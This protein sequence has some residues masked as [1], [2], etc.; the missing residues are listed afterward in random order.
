MQAPSPSVPAARPSAA[1][2]A[3][4]SRMNRSASRSEPQYLPAPGIFSNPAASAPAG[5][6]HVVAPVT[7]F[8]SSL[9]TPPGL[10][11]TMYHSPGVN[12]FADCRKEGIWKISEELER[13][14]CSA[15]HV[16]S[17]GGVVARN[18]TLSG[19][20]DSA[21]EEAEHAVR[22]LKSGTG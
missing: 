17:W 12:C 19:C 18:E 1:V 13:F 16:Q 4:L 14:R 15:Y 2:S 6:P 9:S 3:S 11:S 10:A 8:T 7:R 21:H 20:E 5:A 22:G